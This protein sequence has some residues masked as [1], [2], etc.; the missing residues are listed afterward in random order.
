MKKTFFLIFACI[1]TI[2]IHAQQTE[3]TRWP[4][5]KRGAVSITYDDGSINQF[6]VAVPIMNRLG[7]PGTFFINTSAIPGSTHQP[8]FIGRSIEQIIAETES[9]PTDIGNIFERASAA[10]FVP[11]KGADDYFSRAGGQIDAGRMDAAFQIL[12]DFYAKVRAGEIESQPT[13]PADPTTVGALTWDDARRLTAEGHEFASHM[14]THPFMAALDEANLV[15]ELE[16]S[17]EEILSQLGVRSTISTEMPYGTNDD[18]AVGYMMKVY[19]VSRN[20]MDLPYML[21][22]HRSSR[23][24]PIAPEH[25]YV[26]WQRGIVS[27]TSLDEMNGWVDTAAEQQNMWL[28]TVIHGIDGIG[29]EPLTTSD[30]EAHF[31]HIASKDEL[32]VAT[33]GDAA[34]YIKERMSATVTSAKKGRK[35]VVSVDHPLDKTLFDLPL[36]L[37][38]SVDPA[39]KEVIVKQGKVTKSA[40]VHHSDK[41]AFVLYEAVPGPEKIY[42]SGK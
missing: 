1:A 40:P 9:T 37:K 14:V 38:T 19:P 6:R 41:G 7:L 10:R 15:Y 30:V 31:S 42:L 17:R 28:V 4:D 18:R 3:I 22:L 12:D 34:R 29:W 20:R 11:V 33:F 2:A 13:R 36:T 24:S 26:Q 5:D 8:I 32:W 27:R 25:E 23:L 39:W 16:K 35:I 21:E